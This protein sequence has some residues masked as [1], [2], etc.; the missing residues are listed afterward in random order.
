[1]IPIRK[2][3]RRYQYKITIER[4]RELDEKYFKNI[5]LEAQNFKLSI[6]TQDQED[7]EFLVKV[8]RRFFIIQVEQKN[9]SLLYEM[10][11]V[12]EKAE[13]KVTQEIN[14][15]NHPWL[16][17]VIPVGTVLFGTSQYDYRVINWKEGIAM[18]IDHVVTQVFRTFIEPLK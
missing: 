18:N 11:R 7:V 12:N 6:H 16:D 3:L 5:S 14:P 8:W 17:K 9:D 1:M 4:A 13:F 2:Y 10:C 15:E